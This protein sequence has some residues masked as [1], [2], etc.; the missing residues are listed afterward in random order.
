MDNR[1]NNRLA[2]VL[3]NNL[4]DY[5]ELILSCGASSV[6]VPRNTVLSMGGKPT[7]Y[8][9]FVLDGMTKASVVN[10]NG[11]ERVL[12][13][14]KRNTFCAMDGLHEDSGVFVTITTVIDSHVVPMNVGRLSELMAGNR[15]FARD[16]LLY[17]SDV[18]KLM[19]IDAESQSSN[20]VLNK[21]ANFILLYMQSG[22]YLRYGCLPFSQ[23][24]LASAIGASR[25]Q[26]ARICSQLKKAGIVDIKKRRL[27][28]LRLD[29]LESISSLD[30]QG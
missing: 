15:A 18:I 21:L 3:E 6:C 13:Y 4:A 9:Y 10:I 14:H 17:Y 30:V 19:S 11:Y 7:P 29:A 28:I 20:S 5:R 24:E 25:V 22:D 8:I 2:F 26:V 27:Y 12:G 16:L 1:H 23:Q